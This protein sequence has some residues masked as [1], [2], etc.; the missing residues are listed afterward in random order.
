MNRLRVWCDCWKINMTDH[1]RYILW[2]RLRRIKEHE[3]TIDWEE[4]EEVANFLRTS[5]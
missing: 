3:A 4:M 5:A 1:E 2:D